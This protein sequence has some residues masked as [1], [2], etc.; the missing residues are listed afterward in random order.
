VTTHAHGPH[1]QAKK[2]MKKQTNAIRTLF[3]V[4]LFTVVPTIATINC[5]KHMP[6]TTS[7]HL[8]TVVAAIEL[9][10]GPEHQQRPSSPFLDEIEARYGRGNV[11]DIRDHR[12]N[13]GVLDTRVLEVR[14]AEIEDEVHAYIR[15]VV[16]Q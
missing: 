6:I 15:P 10:D 3:D 14:G 12:D 13:E 9:A 7:Q 4:E 5:E 16:S 1:E 8:S 2:K 11:D